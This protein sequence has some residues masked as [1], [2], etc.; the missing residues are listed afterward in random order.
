M[1]KLQIADLHQVYFKYESQESIVSVHFNLKLLDRDEK[2]VCE[3][4]LEGGG[5][6]YF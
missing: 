4:Q 2:R 1:I 5:V 6:I 3:I